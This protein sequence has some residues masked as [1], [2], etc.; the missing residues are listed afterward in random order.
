MVDGIEA[1]HSPV[2]RARLGAI[3]GVTA[4][5]SMLQSK[6]IAT[7]TDGESVQFDDDTIKAAVALLTESAQPLVSAMRAEELAIRRGRTDPWGP[8]TAS[9]E[10]YVW[11]CW[12]LAELPTSTGSR[13]PS[14]QLVAEFLVEACR[15]ALEIV[16]LI[17]EGFYAGARARWRSIHELVVFGE[18]IGR[19]GDA[20]TASFRAHDVRQKA[21]IAKVLKR[22]GPSWDMT[23]LTPAKMEEVSRAFA[24]A[25]NS[26]GDEFGESDYGWAAAFLPS[27]R[28]AHRASPSAQ[29]TR[30]RRVTFGELEEAVGTTRWRVHY[31][32]ASSYIHA[33]LPSGPDIPG[34]DALSL[35]LALVEPGDG[36]IGALTALSLCSLVQVVTE[37][38]ADP[39]DKPDKLRLWFTFLAVEMARQQLDRQ[40]TEVEDGLTQ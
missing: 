3:D 37:L 36:G 29:R 20:A 24:E 25:R 16:Y 39:S 23:Q 8:A 28:R 32:L 1:L 18:F 30:T 6:H 27:P 7:G 19:H 11:L 40:F 34:N 22:H 21:Q 26:Y 10:E 33:R 5:G 4:A 15:I 38:S 31:L 2:E 9:L 13:S 35:H 12:A 14:R 17:R